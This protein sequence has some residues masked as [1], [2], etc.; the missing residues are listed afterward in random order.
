METKEYDGV[1]PVFIFLKRISNCC[2][3]FL[4]LS[5]EIGFYLLQMVK[6]FFFTAY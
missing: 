5:L 2:L 1:F 4:L 3:F 6:H